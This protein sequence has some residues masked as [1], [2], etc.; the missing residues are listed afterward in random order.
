MEN[1]QGDEVLLMI[2]LNKHI[3]TGNFAKALAEQDI[4]MDEVFYRVN[5]IQALNSHLTGSD[6]IRGIYASSGIDCTGC[7]IYHQE[8]GL[9]DHRMHSLDI[10]MELIF[11]CSAP[12]NLQCV[13]ERIRDTYVDI[14]EKRCKRHNMNNKLDLLHQ[15]MDEYKPDAPGSCQLKRSKQESTNEMVSTYN[16]RKGARRI[17]EK[18]RMVSSLT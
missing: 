6:P 15:Q 9:G 13:I 11:G 16:I 7:F 4:L 1:V 12:R 14:L 3:Y 10:T 2:D 17:V 5:D 8:F 18:R